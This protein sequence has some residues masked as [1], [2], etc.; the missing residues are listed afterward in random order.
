MMSSMQDEVEADVES[1]YRDYDEPAG[2]EVYEKTN[3]VACKPTP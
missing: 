3:S 2:N 1:Q